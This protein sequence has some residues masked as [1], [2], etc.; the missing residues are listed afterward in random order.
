MSLVG[1]ALVATLALYPPAPIREVQATSTKARRLANLRE[2]GSAAV[3]ARRS[4]ALM[5]KVAQL[6]QGGQRLIEERGARLAALDSIRIN[7][8]FAERHFDMRAAFRA[9]LEVRPARAF[10]NR[11]ACKRETVAEAR[12]ARDQRAMEARSAWEE[13]ERARRRLERAESR[14]AELEA[15]AEEAEATS[16]EAFLTTVI[17]FQGR[18][19]RVFLATDATTDQLEDEAQSVFPALAATPVC[20]WVGGERLPRGAPLSAVLQAGGNA[21][22]ERVMVTPLGA[23]SAARPEGAPAT[24]EQMAASWRDRAWTSG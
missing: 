14:L 1:L 21:P 20:L 6:R 4:R 5:L 24:E 22:L 19:F 3:A 13:A 12:V 17:T 10:A 11:L 8:E 15:E 7:R 23:L 2:E 9:E 16:C 18:S